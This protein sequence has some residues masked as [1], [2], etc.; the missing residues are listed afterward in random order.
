MSL[1]IKPIETRKVSRF[2]GEYVTLHGIT[3]RKGFNTRRG[4]AEFTAKGLLLDVIHR[5]QGIKRVHQQQDVQYDI[6]LMKH[7][8]NC[9]YCQEMG[10]VKHN[11]HPLSFDYEPLYCTDGGR[12]EFCAASWKAEIRRL[13]QIIMDGCSPSVSDWIMERV[14]SYEPATKTD[15][16]DLESSN[17]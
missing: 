6:E 4:A 8:F 1:V 11:C 7:V 16:D 17:G 9:Q 12:R 3:K 2:F 10:I 13:G 15:D 14:A 5:G